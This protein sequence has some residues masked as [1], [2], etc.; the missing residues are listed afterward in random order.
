MSSEFFDK[1]YERLLEVVEEHL[2]KGLTKE[3]LVERLTGEQNRLDLNHGGIFA[4]PDTFHWDFSWK[5]HNFVQGVNGFY[6]CGDETASHIDNEDEL[7]NQ[8]CD[9]IIEKLS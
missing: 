7:F 1:G 4:E 8:I 3:D 5:F 9:K 6:N 2:K